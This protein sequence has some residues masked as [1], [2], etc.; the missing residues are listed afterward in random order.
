MFI[1]LSLIKHRENQMEKCVG[2]IPRSFDSYQVFSSS[3]WTITFPLDAISL[4]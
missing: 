2:V 4:S 3:L 1:K